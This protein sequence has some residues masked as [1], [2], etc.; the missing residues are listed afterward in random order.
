MKKGEALKN[1]AI[2]TEILAYNSGATDQYGKIYSRVNF[3]KRESTSLGDKKA[4]DNYNYYNFQEQP[5]QGYYTLRYIFLED[6]KSDYCS[7]AAAYRNYLLSTGQ[8]YAKDLDTTAPLFIETVGGIL[9]T[10]SLVGF[11]Y[12]G[13][14]ALTKYEDNIL[15]ANELSR[16]GIS[17]IKFKLKGFSGKGLQYNH[18]NNIKLI[19]ELGGTKGF[20]KLLSNTGSNISLYPDFRYLTFSSKSGLLAKSNYAV[21]SLDLKSAT[22]ETVN[23]ATLEKNFQLADNLYYLNK[24]CCLKD[25]NQRVKVF[26]QKYSID[27]ISIADMGGSI[28]SDFSPEASYDRQSAVNTTSELIKGLS[29]EFGVMLNK[30]YSKNIRYADYVIEAPLWSSQYNFAESVPFY[31]MVYH[32]NVTYS[33]YSVNLASDPKKEF[34]KCIEH[35]AQLKYTLVYRNEDAIKDSDYSELYSASFWGNLE[36]LTANYKAVS[37]LY[38]KIYDATIL[39]HEKLAPLVYYTE[40]SNGVYTVVNYSDTIFASEYGDVPAENYII[41]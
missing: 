16:K 8:M 6:D 20:K 32:G 36:T 24:I 23:Y 3:L 26:S 22:I 17:N 9:S 11:Q 5:Y 14:T 39:Y 18:E 34:L 38:S 2:C 12:Q 27:N 37:E 15:M 13:I 10:K 30:P 33:G 31:A 4:S 41:G 7:M 21:K 25:I 29:D 35:G 28:S 40:Y 1:S 19:G